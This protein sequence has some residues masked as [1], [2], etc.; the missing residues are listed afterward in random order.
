ME[1]KPK[2]L[3]IVAGIVDDDVK[4]DDVYSIVPNICSSSESMAHPEEN[5]RKLV[6]TLKL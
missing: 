5:L 3:I 6:Q 4:M 1:N 2:R